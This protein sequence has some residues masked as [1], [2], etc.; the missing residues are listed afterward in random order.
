MSF[1]DILLARKRHLLPLGLAAAFAL[2]AVLPATAQDT[3]EKEQLT[4]ALSSPNKPGLLHVKQ[5]A[6]S[7]HVVGYSGKDVVIEAVVHESQRRPRD[8]PAAETGGMRRLDNADGFE[9]TAVEKD[10]RVTVK[11][12]SYRRAIDLTI[13]VPRNFSLQVGTVQNGDILIENVSGELEI[14]NV[15]GSIKLTDVGGSALLNT[16]NGSLTATFKAVTPNTPMAF[17]TVNGKVDVTFPTTIKANLK[18]KSDMG[19][20][21]SDFDMAMEK[22]AKPVNSAQNGVYRISQENWTQGKVNGGGA[23]IT[24]KSLQGNLYVRKAK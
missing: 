10:N 8:K 5:V 14:S 18:L 12:D 16:V 9:L 13:K 4:V 20:I 6:G 21:Y 17:S 15:N 3:S 11:N 2:A 23:E 24:V 22:P 1:P 19:A 7:I